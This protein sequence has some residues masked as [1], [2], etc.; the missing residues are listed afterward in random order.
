MVPWWRTGSYLNNG[1]IQT[2]DIEIINAT[3]GS[4]VSFWSRVRSR[5]IGHNTYVGRRSN[6]HLK[7][8][9]IHGPLQKSDLNYSYSISH[10]SWLPQ[11][12]ATK[13]IYRLSHK[14]SYAYN[15]IYPVNN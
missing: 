7:P 8:T 3:Y 9:P 4:L 1:L 12:V 2:G 5:Y 13:L 14:F 11:A 6:V 10:F 15:I